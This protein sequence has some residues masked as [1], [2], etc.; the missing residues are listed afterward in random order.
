[1][2]GELLEDFST[3]MVTM[4]IVSKMMMT[5]MMLVFILLLLPLLLLLVLLLLLLLLLLVLPLP[6]VMM[7]VTILP[8]PASG[9]RSLERLATATLIDSSSSYFPRAWPEEEPSA[10]QVPLPK[11]QC[12]RNGCRGRGPWRPRLSQHCTADSVQDKAMSNYNR[13]KREGEP[14]LHKATVQ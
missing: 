11:A 1:M 9:L 14:I 5:M 7:I 6:M 8:P 10:F 2:G 13:A 4:V 12:G 3:T